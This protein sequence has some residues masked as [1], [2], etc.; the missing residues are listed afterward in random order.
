[1]PP[2]AGAWLVDA[3][4]Y[5]SRAYVRDFETGGRY[6]FAEERLYSYDASGAVVFTLGLL[7]RVTSGLERIGCTVHQVG[8]KL[9]ELA[10]EANR[11]DVDG[12]LDAFQVYEGQDECLL[13]IA[14]D[15]GSDG[16]LIT[17]PTGF[18]KSVVMRMICRLYP[19]ARVHIA[20]K[21]RPLANEIY[22][23]LAK[24]FPSVGFYGDGKKRD[25]R[26]TV[27]VAD[28]LHHGAGKADI[29]LL[30][31]C[32]VGSTEILTPGGVRKIETVRSGDL[33]YC[34]T[35][36]GRVA[37]VFT[38]PT[39]ELYRMEL[40]D[41][42]FIE[43]TGDHPFFTDSGWVAAAE[44]GGRRTYGPQDV[45]DLWYGL[46]SEVVPA[47]NVE[48][49]GTTR[50]EAVGPAGDLLAIL[51]EEAQEP[52]ARPGQRGEGERY[53]TKDRAQT[54]GSWGQR[55][56]DALT[57]A[58]AAARSGA[59]L[60]SGV[61]LRD[62]G[63]PGYGLPETLQAGS[64]RSEPQGG[65]R[66]GR[67]V[68]Q[69]PQGA[70]EGRQEDGI[71][72]VTRVVRV[73]RVECPSLVPVYNLRVSGHPSYFANG[74]LVHNCHELVAP[75]YMAKIGAYRSARVFGFTA[76]PTGRHDGR[77]VEMEAVAGP[78]LYTMTYQESQAAGRVVPIDVEWL[79]VSG[80]PSVAGMDPTTKD[81]LGVWQNDYR[82]R[83]IAA[84]AALIDPSD[85]TLIMVKTIEHIMRLKALLPGY[86]VVHAADGLESERRAQYVAEGLIGA[87]EPVLTGKRL[88]ALQTQFSAGRL[89]KVISNYVWSTGVNF[90]E[91][92]V[93]IRGDASASAIRDVQIPGRAC[94][95]AP[96]AKTRALL[97]DCWDEFDQSL[98]E[99]SRGRRRNYLSRGWSDRFLNPQIK[100]NQV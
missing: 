34:A 75:K 25:G 57:A 50:T 47:Q 48:Q 69:Q 90:R 3:L 97:V 6:E 91:L 60:D 63:T 100:R 18:G 46:R 20:T 55:E 13:A 71:S 93:L 11:P 49:D 35:G 67:G 58:V 94:R 8:R 96:G 33:V 37:S 92:A 52:H 64:G 44:M 84:R 86:T 82:N 73:S 70:G 43:C 80:G 45:R 2:A 31:E 42:R 22:R 26:V 39:T 62:R 14:G 87:D 98:L 1:M 85:Q 88:D 29:L 77:D 24:V 74:Q 19:K 95:P 41:G 61:R 15:G 7:P 32:F 76:S 51:R 27:F 23:D 83:L 30:D 65:D 66:A 12:L 72:G 10:P 17:C 40:S 4:T 89:K 36:V 79:R 9:A 28:S 16:G 5:Q 38:K 56:A 68:T 53:A 81:R 99:R 54:S 21:A 59:N 78:V